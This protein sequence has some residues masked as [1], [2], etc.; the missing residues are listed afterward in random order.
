MQYL[1]VFFLLLSGYTLIYAGMSHYFPQF[2]MV[3][4]G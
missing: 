3:H 1:V 2:T 4:N